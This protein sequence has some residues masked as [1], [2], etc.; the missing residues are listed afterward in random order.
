MR[1]SASCLLVTIGLTAIAAAADPR[2]N[3]S[4]ELLTKQGV[5]VDAA[6]HWYKVLTGLGISGLQIRSAGAGDEMGISEQTSGGATSYKVTGILSSDNVLHVPG[7]TFKSSDTAGLKKWLATLS[8]QGS[9]GVTEA[10]SAFGMVAKQLALVHSDLSAPVGFS[11]HDMPA[12]QAVAR[13][14]G[15][16]KYTIELDG[17]AKKSLSRQTLA[18]ELEGLTCGTSL[19]AILRDCGLMF[20]PERLAGGEFRYQ[21]LPLSSDVECWPVGWKPKNRPNQLLPVLFDFLNVEIKDISAAEALEAIQGRLKVPFLFD[22]FALAQHQVDLAKSQA[23]VPNKRM[24]Y[25]LILNKVLLQARLKYELRVDEGEKPFLW[26]T[27]V[28]PL[29]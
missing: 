10:R 13:I 26:I 8:D 19:A 16:L 24:T 5:P 25:S 17:S 7:G 11:T 12:A 2:P 9:S 1:R 28:K 20:R 18:D 14:A 22:R 3:V 4:L 29:R 23:D 6:Q 21:V 15:S 27:T